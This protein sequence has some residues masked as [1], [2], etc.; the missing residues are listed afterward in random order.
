[1]RKDLA[2]LRH[3]A[4]AAAR[5]AVGA[6]AGDVLALE[7]DRGRSAPAGGR[8]AVFISVLLPT[9]LRPSTPTISPARDLDADALQHVA[10]R[11]AGA[12][13]LGGEERAPSLRPFPDRCGGR[14]ACA[15]IS[16][17]RAFGEDPPLVQ[18]GHAAAPPRARR[19]CRARPPRWSGPT[20]FRCCSTR[21]VC[22][23]SSG[24]M[25]AVG[26]SSSRMVGPAGQ[27]HGDLEPLQLMVRQLAGR[28][29]A[30]RIEPEPV[31]GVAVAARSAAW[32]RC[33]APAAVSP[34]RG[35]AAPRG[36]G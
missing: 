7:A 31:E 4:D 20:A 3:V 26:S 5:A 28:L 24:D 36:C 10:G 27:H 25:P 2:P 8:S 18:D 12:Q 33:R 14:P 11:L 15:V 32:S 17:T 35:S 1:M 19:R 9:P 6:L 16:S 22:M 21:A 13:V 29:R 23:V 34:P 30:L